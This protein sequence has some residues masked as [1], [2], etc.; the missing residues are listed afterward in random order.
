MPDG[1]D[2]HHQ[3]S[4]TFTHGRSPCQ[5]VFG[6]I[7]RP[8]GDLISDPFSLVISPLLH[9]YTTSG[10]STGCCDEGFGRAL[11][12]FKHQ[13]ALLRKTR[14]QQDLQGLQPGQAVAFWR[15]SGRSRQHKKGAW[16]LARFISHDPDCK[17]YGFRSTPKP[18]RWR[19]IK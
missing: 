3:L 16:A 17:T 7:P 19:T 2:P 11:C 12:Q 18:L 6:E 1:C 5:A 14:R 15:W 10:S 9:S 8:I 13:K 4:C